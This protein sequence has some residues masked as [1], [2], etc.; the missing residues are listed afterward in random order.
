MCFNIRNYIATIREANMNPGM[1]QCKNCWK[2]GHVT[3]S[4]K[5][6]G[7]KCVKYNSSYKS[8]NHQQFTWY[9]KANEK[10]NLPRLETKKEELYLYSFKCANCQG[11][12]QVNS[13]QYLFW[14]HHF[15]HDQH[16]KKQQELHKKRI[17]ICS[18][19]S[20]IQV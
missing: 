8:E 5:I 15:N 16:N 1:L 7:V 11:D 3:L 4:C 19:V 18:A 20:G 2:Q 9:C 14:R 13:N 10:T 6:Q 17:L 12:Y